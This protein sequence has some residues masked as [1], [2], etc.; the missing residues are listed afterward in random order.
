MCRL[1]PHIPPQTMSM[2]RTLTIELG[3]ITSVTNHPVHCEGYLLL[4]LLVAA[5]VVAVIVMFDDTV[6]FPP[7][8]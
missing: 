7:E 3:N 8:L 1:L 6:V 5:V 4:L 2:Q